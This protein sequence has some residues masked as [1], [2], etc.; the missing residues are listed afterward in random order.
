MRKAYADWISKGRRTGF[1][2]GIFAF[3]GERIIK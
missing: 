1:G 3:D 2:K